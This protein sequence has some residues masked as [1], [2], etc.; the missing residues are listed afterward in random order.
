MPT[1]MGEAI[2]IVAIA[3]HYLP[4]SSSRALFRELYQSIGQ[5]T[6]NYSVRESLQ[7]LAAIMTYDPA[8][9]DQANLEALDY[10]GPLPSWF[11]PGWAAFESQLRYP[12]LAPMEAVFSADTVVEVRGD[13]SCVAFADPRFLGKY[14]VELT[15][16]VVLPAVDRPL[17]ELA[18][19][20]LVVVHV[21]LIL[22]AAA[23]FCVLPFAESWYVATPCMM[24]IVIA[25]L[26]KRL[27]CPLT[28][29]ENFLRRC[30]GKPLIKAFL[31]HY[32]IEPVRARL[33]LSGNE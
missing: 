3:D 15:P 32:L 19:R 7:V 33:A 11:Q 25:S 18:W 24:I 8:A 1:T 2:S 13:G 17:L 27:D 28:N 4:R 10:L 23:A 14:P 26:S 30:L 9:S 16:P 6:D 31:R 22:T 29:L 12:D 5:T 20:A 21:L